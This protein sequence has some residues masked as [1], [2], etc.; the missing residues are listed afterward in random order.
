MCFHA[1][2]LRPGLPSIG[3]DTKYRL[4]QFR[5]AAADAVYA[6]ADTASDETPHE[7]PDEPTNTQPHSRAV[8][9]P[10]EPALSKPNQEP[11]RCANRESNR[12]SDSL[13]NIQPKCFAY[14]IAILQPH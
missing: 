2:C 5:S 4:R 11:N 1:R 7:E 10:N 14:H 12:I 3:M 13:S 6:A 9:T 8:E